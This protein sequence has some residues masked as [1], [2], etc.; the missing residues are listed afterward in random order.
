MAGVLAV[1]GELLELAAAFHELVEHRLV[2]AAGGLQDPL[3]R[4][5]VQER[6]RLDA[7]PQPPHRREVVAAAGEK[8]L[9]GVHVGA[10]VL[11][12]ER[13]GVGHREAGHVGERHV[14][15][16]AESVV[17]EIGLGER[18]QQ[19]LGHLLE[20]GGALLARVALEEH[21]PLPVQRERHRLVR[22]DA[23]EGVG[24]GG[25]PAQDPRRVLD[26]RRPLLLLLQEVGE[27]GDAVVGLAE[28]ARHL[29]GLVVADRREL[30][31]LF[32]QLGEHALG[33]ERAAALDGLVEGLL[34][35]GRRFGAEGGGQRGER[36]QNHRLFHA[37]LH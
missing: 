6:L 18:L 15:D 25:L 2:L 10:R 31:A 20:V 12:D 37:F 35:L 5:G 9:D 24:V 36:R 13:L 1:A 33:G 30:A 23:H 28:L 4:A 34:E 26:L 29:R 14:G 11:F 22:G 17:A 19:R 3:E 8:P 16:A 32:E 27:A 7:E 21:Q